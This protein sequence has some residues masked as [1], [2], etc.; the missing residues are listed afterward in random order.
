MPFWYDE[1]MSEDDGLTNEQRL[2]RVAM[3]RAAR[4]LR[5][6]KADLD[7]AKQLNVPEEQLPQ[8]RA[9]IAAA[10]EEYMKYAD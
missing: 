5:N 4:R 9:E 1:P 6:A 7:M 3:S 10:F 8:Y 2:Q